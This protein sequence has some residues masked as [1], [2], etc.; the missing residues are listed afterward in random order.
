MKN[1]IEKTREF[2]MTI[3]N[4]VVEEDMSY[5]DALLYVMEK[6][7]LDEDTVAKLVKKNSVIK[8]KLELES[9]DLNLL[10]TEKRNVLP[11]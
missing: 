6:E 5:M 11:I 2:A 1:P 10:K 3:E 9:E 8:I 4:V 7:K